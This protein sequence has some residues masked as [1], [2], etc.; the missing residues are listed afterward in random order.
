MIDRRLLTHFDWVTLLITVALSAAGFATIYSATFTGSS[1]IYQ[2]ELY[3]LII[4]AVF[5]IVAIAINYS[6]FERLAYPIYGVALLLLVAVLLFGRSTGG[7]TRWLDLGIISFQPSELAKLALIIALAKYF[8]TRSIPARGLGLKELAPPFVLMIVPFALIAKEPD[9]GTAL[10][11][12]MIFWS[13]MLTIKVRRR[14]IAA[15][16]L[17][18]CAFIPIAWMGLK[19]YQKARLTGFIR[20]ETDPLGAGYHLIQSKI[21]IGSGGYF[22]KGFTMGTQGKLMFLPEQH[23][24]FIFSVLAE[25]WGLAGSLILLVLFLGLILRG[26][27]TAENSKDKFGFLLALGI[28]AMLF[29]HMVFNLGMVSGLLPVVGVPL[30]FIS[31]GGSFLITSMIAV[32]LLINIK[33]RRFTF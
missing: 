6:F 17:L 2:K 19:G 14:I 30:P 7:A 25:E 15:I 28:S 18:V 21:A 10:I 4:G 16:V 22:G 27:N 9:L 13:M 29:W 24:D 32:G 31:Y 3:W 33:I 12:W 11:T 5:F 23:T 20:P 8:S 1:S 26:L